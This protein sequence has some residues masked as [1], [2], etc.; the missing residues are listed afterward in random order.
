MGSCLQV[1]TTSSDKAIA[2]L[3]QL[4]AWTELQ[5]PDSLEMLIY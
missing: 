1:S 3:G 2:S 5:V 4:A